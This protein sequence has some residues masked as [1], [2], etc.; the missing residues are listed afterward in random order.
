MKGE[1]E[2]GVRLNFMREYKEARRDEKLCRRSILEIYEYTGTP[3]VHT[4]SHFVLASEVEISTVKLAIRDSFKG[5]AAR[6]ESPGALLTASNHPCS[7]HAPCVPF[8]FLGS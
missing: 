7:T 5:T 2:S 3:S 6:R 1:T 4:G 8:F